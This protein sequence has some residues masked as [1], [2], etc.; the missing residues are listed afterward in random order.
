MVLCGTVNSYVSRRGKTI[1]NYNSVTLRKDNL[2]CSFLVQHLKL[3]DL[4][5]EHAT[6]TLLNISNI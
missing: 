2:I 5:R 6:V 3:D 4:D 1:T